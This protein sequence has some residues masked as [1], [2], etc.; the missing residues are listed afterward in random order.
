MKIGIMSFT[1]GRQRVAEKTREICKQFENEIAQWI[2]DQGHEVV[3]Y[4]GVVW[5][6]DTARQAAAMVREQNCDAAVFNYAVWSYPDLTAQVAKLISVPILQ[7]GNIN[8]GYP[9]WVAFFASNG[10]LD[11]IGVPYWRALG[12]IKDERVQAQVRRF[13]IM[14]DP[15]RRRRGIRAAEQ[16]YGMRYGEFDGPSM[17]MYTGHVDQSQWMAQFG[18]HVYHRSQ[19]TLVKLMGKVEDERVEAGLKWLEENCAEIHWDDKMLTPGLDG[20]LAR[21]VRF[22]L[23]LKDFCREEGIDFCGITGQ[24]DMT[25]FEDLCIA[26]VPEALMNDIA[27]WEENPKPVIVCATECDSNGALTMQLMHLLT[28]E[29]ALFA[30]LRHY[31]EDLDLYD[32]CNSGQHA[33]WFAERSS[34]Y[35]D[36][37]R[38]VHLH[39]AESFYFRAGGASVKF[40]AAP[41]DKVTY[42]R[43]TRYKGAFRMHIFT[44][45][46]IELPEDQ[47]EELA[48]QTTYTWPH[49][50]AKFDVPY[51]VL[52]QR[53]SCNHIHACIGDWVAEL[54]AACEYLGIEPIVLSE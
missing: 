50:W 38:H 5:N 8:P 13:L 36:N 11:E 37:W 10:A 20:T 23:A 6:W 22:Y 29:P 46:F 54:V 18:V 33:P 12:D 40:Y 28:G 48:K 31:H 45:S 47:A 7:I 4:E 25:E 49:V 16:L 30:D 44:G 42:A 21:Q 34:N 27:D 53:F 1:D 32:L 41:A 52:A 2:R 19:L 35:K 15:D 51:P 14:A 17:G 24:L 9:G 3:Q 43:I 39:P 26:D